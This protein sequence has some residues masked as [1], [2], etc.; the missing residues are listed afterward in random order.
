MLVTVLMK[1]L[2]VYSMI[3]SAWV[4]SCRV[5]LISMAF[6]SLAGSTQLQARACQCGVL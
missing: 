3:C 4:W 2:P 6:I 1:S 5:R